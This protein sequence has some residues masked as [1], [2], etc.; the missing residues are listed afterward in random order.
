[1]RTWNSAAIRIFLDAAEVSP[2]AAQRAFID[3]ACRD[4]ADLRTEVES[5]LSADADAGDFLESPLLC[6]VSESDLIGADTGVGKYRLL[7]PIGEGG[8]AIVYRAEQRVPMQRMVAIKI[9][10]R[11]LNTAQVIARFGSE[12]Q[13]LAR[14]EHPQIAQLLDAGA[15]PDGRPYFVMEL[16]HG[17]PITDY[18]DRQALPL[19]VRLELFLDACRA[20]QYAHLK[21]IIHRDIKPSNVLVA[22]GDDRPTVKVIDFGIAKA[23]HSSGRDDLNLTSDAQLLGTPLYMS[24]EQASGNWRDVDTRSDIYSLGA[25]LYE[26]LTGTTPLAREQLQELPLDEVRRMICEQEPP[27]PSFRANTLGD[28]LTTISDRRGIAPARL[29]RDMR[30][31]L[32]WI[33]MRS[34]EKERDRRYQTVADFAEDIARYRRHEPV[35]ACPPSSMYRLRKFVRRHRTPV[36]VGFLV[37]VTLVVGTFISW[38]QA[39]RAVL[40]EKLAEQRLAAEQRAHE[41]EALARRE[42]EENFLQAR[43][44]VERYFTLVSES[45]LLDVPGMQSLREELLLAARDY[46]Q[47]FLRQHTEDP[48]LRAELAASWFR[49]AQIH[50]SIDAND[51]AV[52]DLQH[53]LET[54]HE[55]RV[56]GVDPGILRRKLAGV[57]DGGRALHGG[58]RGPTDPS[59]AAETLLQTLALWDELAHEDPA[60]ARLANDVAGLN[61]LL[62]DLCR[63]LRQPAEAVPR[64]ERAIAI[65]S[66]LS[67]KDPADTDLRANRARCLNFLSDCEQRLHHSDAALRAS[68][69][70]LQLLEELVAQHP[71]VPD[72]RLD[73]ALALNKSGE[74]LRK[75]SAFEPA[76]AALKQAAGLLVQLVGEAPQV[77]AFQ[78]ALAVNWIEQG[79]MHEAQNRLGDADAFSQEAAARLQRLVDDYPNLPRYREQLAACQHSRA[80]LLR[81][82]DRPS[83]AEQPF[84]SSLRHWEQLVTDVPAE[85]DFRRRL[86]WDLA[87]SPWPRLREPE[88]ALTLAETAVGLAPESSIGWRTLGVAQYRAGKWLPATASLQKAS[89]L[90]GGDR[91]VECLFLSMAHYQLG[92]HEQARDFYDRALSVANA[93]NGPHSEVAEFQ[94]E[95]ERLLQSTG[96]SPILET[97]P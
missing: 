54:V 78:E 47:E 49:L 13:T 36:A 79:Q 15:T 28:M 60:D 39:Q 4:D 75:A 94:A 85:A 71:D 9:L 34:L 65:W 25:M 55:L 93:G 22:N 61:L 66:D 77:P 86:A 59:R 92:H 72:Y 90:N 2:R 24:P 84:A 11:G 38:R 3:S 52:D 30:G 31:D 58:T 67:R 91:C 45:R 20:V 51:A 62:G 42:A 26:L 16:V 89:E 95:A 7:E 76:E 56:A 12:R 17:A 48:E 35:L 69:E 74:R 57:Y 43:S 83:D 14:L 21:G 33:V 68:N 97:K 41:A 44:A 37:A 23:I 88:R 46:H 50:H 19:S 6:P 81:A 80:W 82:L 10:K 18:C 70:A 29:P 27:I 40:A 64:F 1:M 63:G 73:L 87:T 8:F 32:D 96:P 53:G 5:L